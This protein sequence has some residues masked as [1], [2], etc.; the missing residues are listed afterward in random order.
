MVRDEDP[1]AH[2]RNMKLLAKFMI[3]V[4]LVFLA[5]FAGYS[6][7][8]EREYVIGKLSSILRYSTQY[9]ETYFSRVEKQHRILGAELLHTRRQ[10]SVGQAITMLNNYKGINHDQK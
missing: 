4:S 1:D 10:V 9:C 6:W 7:V 3:G 8:T 5:G 2:L